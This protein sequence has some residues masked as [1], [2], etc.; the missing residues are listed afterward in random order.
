MNVAAVIFG[1]HFCVIVSSGLKHNKYRSHYIISICLSD[2]ETLCRDMT[3]P[4][5]S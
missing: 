3:G 5:V 1:K 2:L 4:P